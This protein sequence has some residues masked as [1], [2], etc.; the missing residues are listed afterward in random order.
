MTKSEKLDDAHIVV[1]TEVEP[2]IMGMLADAVKDPGFDANKLEQL[3]MLKERVDATE[4]KKA[5]Q[6]AMF[7]FQQDPPKIIKDAP[8]Y[9]KDKDKGA[10][11]YFAKFEKTMN[12]VRPALLKVGIVPTWSSEPLDNGMTKV[13]CMLRHKLGHEETA[14]MA[15]APEAGGSKNAIQGI[16]SSVSY[17]RRYTFLSV[18]GLVAE[19][20]D[21]DGNAPAWTGPL[22]KTTLKKRGQT[23]VTSVV[24]AT[25]LEDL[26]AINE[27]Y[28]DV[29]IQMQKDLPE[30][31]FGDDN[32]PGVQKA[33]IDKREEINMRKV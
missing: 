32:Q 20:E 33:M 3:I 1:H 2:S 23:L 6:E 11:Y 24:H 15:G 16:G 28:G 26:T 14:S 17:L 7:T 29:M 25:I 18:T 22:N 10:Q 27:E 30:W 12:D 21:T 31:Y 19:G 4:A 8:V 5:F 13:T 9:G